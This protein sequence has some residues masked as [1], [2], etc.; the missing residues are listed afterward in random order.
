MKPLLAILILFAGCLGL[1]AEVMPPA[2]AHYFTLV[3]G[4][5]GQSLA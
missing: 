1:R 5:L 2:P 4:L 3:S